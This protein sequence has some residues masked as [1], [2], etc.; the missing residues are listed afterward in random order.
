[1]YRVCKSHKP[2]DLSWNVRTVCMK[3]QLFVHF[4]MNLPEDPFKSFKDFM[5]M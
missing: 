2:L 3:Y 4:K 1:M 5:Q